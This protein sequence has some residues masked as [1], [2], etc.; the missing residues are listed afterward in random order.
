M[1]NL[2]KFIKKK[3]QCEYN[4]KKCYKS[5]VKTINFLVET[6]ISQNINFLIYETPPFIMGEANYD[7][8]E[9]IDYII[10]KIKK[11]KNFKR[12]LEE[13]LFYEP[14]LVYIKWDM[15]KIEIIL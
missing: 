3:K 11:D 15:N 13:I 1:L 5:I 6:T 8:L 10:R 2:D 4:K 7:M 9:C 12:V 14:N